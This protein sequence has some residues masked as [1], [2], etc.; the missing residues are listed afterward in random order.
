MPQCKHYNREIRYICFC[1]VIFAE[2]IA[3]I[4]N[5]K[6]SISK[7]LFAS[8]KEAELKNLWTKVR[9]VRLKSAFG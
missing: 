9:E 8:E 2:K 4:H 3:Y 5:E 7:T 1:F 6:E